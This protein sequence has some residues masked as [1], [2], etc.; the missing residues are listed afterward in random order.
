MVGA[1]APRGGRVGGGGVPHVVPDILC[2]AGG[3]IV[4][5][6]E[7]IQGEQQLFWREAEVFDKLYRIMAKAF[8]RVVKHARNKKID[9]RMA[10][11][12]LGI[13]KVADAKE[14]RGLFP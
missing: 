2:N 10:A 4:S 14:L 11:L 8:D 7:W 5:Y 12:S 1:A 9:H 3:V 13:K 6:F